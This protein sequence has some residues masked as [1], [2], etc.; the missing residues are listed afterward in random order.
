V[1]QFYDS[2]RFGLIP[3]GADAALYYDGKFAVTP[4]QAKRFGRVRWITVT[5]GASAAAHAGAIDFELYNPAF[6]GDAMR[7][8]ALARK[9]MNTRARVYSSRGNL[10]RAL[11]LVGD[12]QNVVFWVATLDERQW[13]ATDLL[14][15]IFT[16]DHVNLPAG[17]LWA[18]QWNGGPS[19]QY[20][21]STLLGAW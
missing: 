7:E 8:W 5:G 14:A 12:L 6:N 13:G 9:A 16:V 21:T 19:A 4:G 15:D 3:A 11:N 1:T 18:N 20:D 2:A 17:R 10:Q